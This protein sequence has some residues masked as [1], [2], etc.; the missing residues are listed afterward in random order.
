MK[1]LL[2]IVLFLTLT[3]ELCACTSV[4]PDDK[5]PYTDFLSGKL[6][7]IN[8]KGEET[9]IT[10]FNFFG[11]ETAYALY[12][13]NGDSNPELLVNMSPELHIFTL[14][15]NM[16]KLWRSDTA[17]SSRPLNNG[18]ILYERHGGGPEHI[19]YIYYVPDFYGNTKYEISFSYWESDGEN[20]EWYD[21]N[22]EEVSKEA[23][24]AVTKPILLIGDNKIEWKLINDKPSEKNE[25]I[26][27]AVNAYNKFLSG[28]LAAKDTESNKPIYISDFNGPIDMS[29]SIY[30]INFDDTP[31]LLTRSYG[32]DV[33]SFK[34][35]EIIYLYSSGS[36]A[37]HGNLGFALEDGRLYY[38]L[39]TTGTSH[40]FVTVDKD[41]NVT[42]FNFFDGDDSNNP[43]YLFGGNEVSKAEFDSLTAPYFAATEKKVDLKWKPI[44]KNE[45]LLGVLNDNQKFIINGSSFTLMEYLNSVGGKSGFNPV[46]YTLVD[47]DSD[48][49]EEL[50]IEYGN[51]YGFLIVHYSESDGKLYGYDEVYRGI[52]PLK[53]DGRFRGSDGAAYGSIGTM[54]FIEGEKIITYLAEWDDI[55]KIYKINGK[56]VEKTEFDNYIKNF[57]N[58]PNATWINFD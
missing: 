20:P 58:T 9:Y 7:F 44:N 25:F 8:D 54:S 4:A 21:I 39:D 5:E 1:K 3:L 57:E 56:S 43:L 52:N 28:E 53:A 11:E 17:Y 51:Y 15:D 13:M 45:T 37:L 24:D 33:F 6:P 30:D 31:E 32:F 55:E 47:L 40:T 46:K 23:Y 34:N 26:N 2:A 12:D 10:D 14:A 41:L 18:A 27:N 36:F 22:G 35:G 16:V 42:E 29:Y 49:Q 38:A 19:N 48:L 50:I